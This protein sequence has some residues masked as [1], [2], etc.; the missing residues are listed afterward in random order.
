MS[1]ESNRRKHDRYSADDVQGNFSYAVDATVMNISLGGFAV[2]TVTQL[3]I[4]RVYRFRLGSG[5]D[6]VQLSGVVR[7]CKMAGTK[8]SDTGD[9]IP[10]YRAGIAFEEVLTDQA[11]DLRRFMEKSIV[12]D[13]KRRVFGRFSTPHTE[14]VKLESDSKFLVKQISMSGLLVEA[15]DPL[16]EEDIFDLELGLGSET[17]RS[18]VRVA[19]VAKVDS[20]SEESRYRFGLE[21]LETSAEDLNLLK[22]FIS[23]QLMDSSSASI[24]EIE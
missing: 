2:R 8:K 18:P 11:G 19:H 13:I 17:F 15:D 24:E 22:E 23:S 10:V 14:E 16:I 6:S 9:V 1:D 3:T 20:G 7:W 21:F 5:S 12:V 4:G